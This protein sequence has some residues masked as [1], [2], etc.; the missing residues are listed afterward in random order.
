MMNFKI[1]KTGFRGRGSGFKEAAK[2]TICAIFI[3]LGS[4]SYIWPHIRI[5]K[6]SYE[7]DKLRKQYEKLLQINHLMKIEVSS[8]RS[9]EKIEK[10]A[11]KKL[12]MVF[13]DDSHVV[14]VR[15][16]V[17]NVHS[18]ASIKKKS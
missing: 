2:L 14:I 7:K 5:V 3:L 9:L 4:L 12:N 17:K 10:I 6:L 15:T 18:H 13:P 16:G 1:K 11:I 8:L